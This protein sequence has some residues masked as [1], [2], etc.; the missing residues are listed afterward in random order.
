[1]IKRSI[2]VFA[3]LLLFPL[4]ASCA[5]SQGQPYVE[6]PRA[7]ETESGNKIEVREFFWY[8]CQHCYALEPSVERWLKTK[9]AN[10]VFIRTPA[11]VGSWALH[12]KAYYAFEALD[13]VDKVHSAFFN[14]IHRQNRRLNDEASLA[15]FAAENGV[16][17][18]RFREAFNSFGVR[19]KVEKA[20]RL[21]EAAGLDSVPNLL[22]AGK[23]VTSPSLANGP[24][25]T[26]KIV[27]Q[28]VKKA[29]PAPAKASAP[30]K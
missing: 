16:D 5:E 6:L 27:D 22:V 30:K 9:P 4:F 28:L 15:Q 26:F 17:A 23:Y 18:A 19:M 1:M 20:R 25:G 21:Y 8:G 11:A 7:L 2:T 24:E 29:A 14:A 3:A 12:A 10:V 13:A